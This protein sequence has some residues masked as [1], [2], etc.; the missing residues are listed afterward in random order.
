MFVESFGENGQWFE[1]IDDLGDL[2]RSSIAEGDVVL[3]K[4]SRSTAMERIVNV[5]TDE[6]DIAPADEARS[7]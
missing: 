6:A 7:A 1:D 4:G 3:V 5:L 2:L